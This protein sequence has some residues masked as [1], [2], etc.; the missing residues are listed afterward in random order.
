MK[1]TFPL[2]IEGKHRDRVIEAAK[3][4]IRKYIR[5]ERRK[6]LPE[7]MDYWDFDCKF[8][9]TAQDAT[10][11]HFATITAL[12]DAAAQSGAAAFYLE[13]LAKAAKR[14]VRG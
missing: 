9:T 1:K 7:G 11:V 4:E 2:D 6:P 8:G 10:G 14:A 5:R 3:H 12:I 13:L